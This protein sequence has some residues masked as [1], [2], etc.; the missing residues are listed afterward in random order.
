MND[1]RILTIAL[2]VLIVLLS[3]QQYVI[4]NFKQPSV[5]EQLLVEINNKLDFLSSK[6]DSI[7]VVIAEVDKEI[8]KN[9]K[10]FKEVVNNVIVQPT[11][12]D[13]LF[14]IDYVD[15]FIEEKGFDYN[16]R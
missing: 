4:W 13:S 12:A 9:E 5:E 15:R 16:L 8:I 10:H 7:R 11:Y 6:K 3:I 14:I 2:I 1:K